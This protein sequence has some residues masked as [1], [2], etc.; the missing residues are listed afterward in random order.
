MLNEMKHLGAR[1]R[2]AMAAEL[3]LGRPRIR[4]E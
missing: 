4:V 3:M 2:R 1:K